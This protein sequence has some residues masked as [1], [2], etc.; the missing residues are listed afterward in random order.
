MKQYTW[1]EWQSS[2][3]CWTCFSSE[4]TP[5]HVFHGLMDFD[6][7]YEFVRNQ[8]RGSA[9]YN[10]VVVFDEDADALMWKMRYS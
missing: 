7:T 2:P 9:Y 8:C 6:E 3:H 10:G 5:K 4:W 1:E